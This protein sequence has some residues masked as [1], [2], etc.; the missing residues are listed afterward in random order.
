[1]QV[2]SFSR[3]ISLLFLETNMQIF[4]LKPHVGKSAKKID[5]S[6]V[7]LYKEVHVKCQLI[8]KCPFGVFKSPKKPNEIF[9]VFLEN[10]RHQKV[11]LNLTDL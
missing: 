2:K 9:V 6:S 4:K 10:L 5:S 1:M 8:S 3:K 7:R 11:I